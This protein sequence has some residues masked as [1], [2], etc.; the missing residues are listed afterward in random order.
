MKSDC[1]ELTFPQIVVM[2]SKI[3]TSDRHLD[4]KDPKIRTSA[5]KIHRSAL[6]Q[7]IRTSTE[8]SQRSTPLQKRAKDPR[9]CSKRSENH[10]VPVFYISHH[11]DL[12]WR[13]FPK[14]ARPAYYGTATEGLTRRPTTLFASPNLILDDKCTSCL[15]VKYKDKAL[16]E[17]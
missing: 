14:R 16:N 2:L 17:T 13:N 5:E 3:H 1:E 9:L 11:L 7:K 8:K 12:D 4:R 6:L 15:Y 10:R